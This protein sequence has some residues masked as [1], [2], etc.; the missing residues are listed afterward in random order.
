MIDKF[1]LDLISE[2]FPL[3]LSLV[4]T[5]VDERGV[6]EA[7]GCVGV[8]KPTSLSGGKGRLVRDNASLSV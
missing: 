8:R 6:C 2:L 4:L 1:I 5:I 7:T 3:S